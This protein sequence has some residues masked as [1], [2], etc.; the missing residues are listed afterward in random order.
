MHEGRANQKGCGAG[1]MHTANVVL[2]FHAALCY[3][4]AASGNLRKQSLAGFEMDFECLEITVVYSDNF[5]SRLES[6]TQCRVV[7]YF[8]ERIQ[9]RRLRILN[10]ATQFEE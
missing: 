3:S 2:G 6:G 4:D 7:M 5:S 1:V 9:T 8:D 10:K